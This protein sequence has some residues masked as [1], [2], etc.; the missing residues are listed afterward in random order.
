MS[1]AAFPCFR[2]VQMR[3]PMRSGRPSR[4]VTPT[5]WRFRTEAA[6]NPAIPAPTMMTCCCSLGDKMVDEFSSLAAFMAVII[7]EWVLDIWVSAI[8]PF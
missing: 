5:P 2:L 4:I 6:R 3:P 7:A 8:T 1:L